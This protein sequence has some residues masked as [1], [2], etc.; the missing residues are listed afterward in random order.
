MIQEK[1]PTNTELITPP[2]EKWTVPMKSNF[3][4]RVEVTG[5]FVPEATVMRFQKKVEDIAVSMFKGGNVKY[6]I[7]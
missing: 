3:T 4:L 1:P 7:E 5:V 6:V 2:P